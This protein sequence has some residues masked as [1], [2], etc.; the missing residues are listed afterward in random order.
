MSDEDDYMDE[1]A[2]LKRE[3]QRFNKNKRQNTRRKQ[4]R[5]KKNRRNNSNQQRWSEEFVDLENLDFGN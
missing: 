3:E 4:G 1:T 2:S 5:G